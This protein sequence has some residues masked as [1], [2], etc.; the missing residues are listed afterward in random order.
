M[1]SNEVFNIILV[2]VGIFI[3]LWI[4]RLCR[5]SLSIIEIGVATR[6]RDLGVISVFLIFLN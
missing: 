6:L 4:L 5:V 3:F 2:F 1:I